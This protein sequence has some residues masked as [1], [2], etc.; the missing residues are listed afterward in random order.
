[1]Y[2]TYAAAEVEP[3]GKYLRRVTR[4]K[5]SLRFANDD[6]VEAQHVTYTK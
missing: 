6:P 5:L 4:K 3:T 1:M 2:G